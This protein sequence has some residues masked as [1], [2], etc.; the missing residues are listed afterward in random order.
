MKAFEEQVIQAGISGSYNDA[1]IA[2]LMNP[3]MQDEKGSK[4]VLDELLEAHKAF[5]PQFN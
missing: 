5:L 4:L 2:M 3:L 1:Y